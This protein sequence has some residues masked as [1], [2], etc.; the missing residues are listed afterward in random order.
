MPGTRHIYKLCGEKKTLKDSLNTYSLV[1]SIR[2]SIDH[3]VS[4]CVWWEWNTQQ[5]HVFQMVYG[6]HKWR[7]RCAGPQ[8][9]NPR[10]NIVTP[11][12]YPR[13]LLYVIY[14][15]GMLSKLY[16]WGLKWRSLCGG[17]Q[18]ADLER[19]EPPTTVVKMASDQGDARETAPPPVKK[20]RT[21]IRTD[22][23][24]RAEE[25]ER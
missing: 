19:G 14:I 13:R 12:W 16:I 9:A 5:W 23:T 6:G 24:E 11:N 2:N 18:V 3:P 8:V 21:Q 17:P 4:M 15:Y 20:C 1:F 25:L 10:R 22:D 7:F